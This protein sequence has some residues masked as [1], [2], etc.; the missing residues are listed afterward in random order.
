MAVA[1]GIAPFA[2]V[3]R[4]TTKK[5]GDRSYTVIRAVFEFALVA[6]RLPCGRCFAVLVTIT[7]ALHAERLPLQVHTPADGLAQSTVHRI[8][9]D[10]HGFLWFG[11]SEGLSRYDGY[12]FVTYRDRTRPVQPRIRAILDASD[13]TL[14]TGGDA[15]LC[16]V[17]PL[18]VPAA[19]YECANPPSG[20]ASVHALFQERPGV[21]LAGADTGLYRVHLVPQ[22]R[23]TSVPLAGPTASPTVWDIV[24]DR[25]GALWIASTT[26]IHRLQPGQPSFRLS[27]RDG[28]PSDEVFSLELGAGEVLWAATGQGLCQI[29]INGDSPSVQRVFTINDGLP[30]ITV[31]TVHIGMQDTLWVGTSSGIAELVRDSQG[32][33]TRF[34]AYSREHGLSHL[35]IDTMEDDRAG[36]LWIGSQ[37][38]GAMKLSRDGFVS[39]GPA[40]GL[41]SPYVMAMLETRAGQICAMTRVPGAFH[42]NFLEGERFRSVPVPV[43]PSFYSS[44]WSGWYQVAAETPAGEWWI[45]SER[46]LLLFPPGWPLLGPAVDAQARLAAWQ[47]AAV[48]SALRQLGR[49]A[50]MV[51]AS[52]GLAPCVLR[53][54]QIAAESNLLTPSRLGR[55]A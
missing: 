41:G 54:A 6:S 46:G 42:L 40:D 30:A 1:A 10:R 2:A 24:P 28:L 35:D 15:G 22:P 9:R 8:H 29:R 45:A 18:A 16:R 3:A 44:A 17:N 47:R 21:L 55:A 32:R 20:R 26:G 14:W 49:R 19:V 37:S 34:R 23:F 48:A 5:C 52:T 4:C 53:D 13:G 33:I 50:W 11:T 25:S 51:A 38:G 39:Y 7:T 31:K 27:T 12:E 43:P 36:N